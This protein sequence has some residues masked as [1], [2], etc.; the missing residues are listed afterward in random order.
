M[1]YILEVR[2]ENAKVRQEVCT[3]VRSTS[4]IEQ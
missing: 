4:Y 3:V 1:S 2:P